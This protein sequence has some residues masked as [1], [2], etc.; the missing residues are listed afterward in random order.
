MQRKLFIFVAVLVAVVLAIGVYAYIYST[1]GPY[2]VELDE[3]PNSFTQEL[4]TDAAQKA[5]EARG[6]SRSTWDLG[7]GPIPI[8]DRIVTGGFPPWDPAKHRAGIFVM[9][10]TGRRTQLDELYLIDI[11][12]EGKVITCLIRRNKPSK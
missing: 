9:G 12:L 11:K 3:V 4:A 2:V 5:M 7:A 1:S 10:R 8:G 6:F